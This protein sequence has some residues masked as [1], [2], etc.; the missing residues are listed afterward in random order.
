MAEASL[1]LNGFKIK[2]KE[3]SVYHSKD[4]HKQTDVVS[5]TVFLKNLALT[6]TEKSLREFI[7]EQIGNDSVEEVRLIRKADGKVKGYAYIQL[8]SEANCIEAVK[9]LNQ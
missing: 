4:E 2:G 6:S 1:A 3:I 9:K 7:S 8:S 5:R